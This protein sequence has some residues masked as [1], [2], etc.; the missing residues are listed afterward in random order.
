MVRACLALLLLAAAFA[1]AGEK[2]TYFPQGYREWPVVKFKFIGPEHPDWA[3]QGGLRS[4][5]ANEAARASWGRFRE[6][7]V[8]VDERLHTRLNERK[9]WEADGIAHV[10]VMRKDAR[11]ADT[12]GWYF[13]FFPGGG[14]AGMPREQ[15]KARCFDA[16]HGTQEARDYVFSDPRL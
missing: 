6:G 5:F 10:A 7:S 9:V 16:C 12:G 8:I 13:D 4:H 15:A 14:T 3:A 2:G 11:F 1:F